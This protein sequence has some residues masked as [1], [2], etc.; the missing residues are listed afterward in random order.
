MD[1]L[2]WEAVFREIEAFRRQLFDK[3]DEILRLQR[4]YD[5][6][7]RELEEEAV[8]LIKESGCG[9]LA[10][11]LKHPPLELLLQGIQRRQAYR[12]ALGQPLR[13]L[14]SGAEE[15]LF[16][17]RR[18]YIDLQVLDVAQGLD[19]QAQHQAIRS[20]LRAH[21]PTVESLSIRAAG[22]SASQELLWRR[23]AEQARQTTFNAED[24]INQSIVAE[25]CAGN[26]GRLAE[27]TTLS[28]KGAGCLAESGT[29][30][31]FLNRVNQL[32]PLAAQKLAE[33][34][35]RWLGLNGLKRLPPETARELF[36]WPGE[37]ISL[38]GLSEMAPEAGRYLAG[39][40]G[41]QVELMGLR[42]LSALDALAGVGGVG[43]KTL[44]AG[45]HSPGDRHAAPGGQRPRSSRDGTGQVTMHPHRF[46][47]HVIGALAA[48]MLTAG[49]SAADGGKPAEL[50]RALEDIRRAEQTV[51]ARA[52]QAEALR[53]HL[54]QE[55]EGL[56]AEIRDEQRRNGA[57][58]YPGAV[59]IPRVDYNLRL[60]QRLNGYLEQID[61]R[62]AEFQAV[63]AGFERH[64][65]RIR[66]EL[67][68]LRT[69][70]DADISDLLR[71]LAAALEEVAARC[72]APLVTLPTVQRSTESIRADIA[73]GR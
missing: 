31:L 45:G 10:A 61:A 68:M 22:A 60:L 48:L 1:R 21:E 51:R 34:P 32:S 13:R 72:A 16:L 58:P 27:L 12:D 6:G 53:S 14:E 25:A 64:R 66:D 39:W 30:E 41:R 50:Q 67:R 9:T 7:I 29:Q 23:L 46:L 71:Q 24:R 63:S 59:Q 5:Y 35:G 57:Q 49:M 38:N 33:W 73:Q 65:E 43:R 70:K 3:R 55:G 44:R 42:R 11:A 15:L 62:L 40:R 52:V 47:N 17:Q 20:A 4:H 28:L 36:A 54:R 26:L 56:K 19:L 8:R 18:A 69:L 2:E 37:W